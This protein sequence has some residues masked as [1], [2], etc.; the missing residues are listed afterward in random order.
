MSTYSSSFT[1]PEIG[2]TF[3]N[4]CGSCAQMHD[5]VGDN[6][7]EKTIIIK[8]GFYHIF[9]FYWAAQESLSTGLSCVISSFGFNNRILDLSSDTILDVVCWESCSNC[10]TSNNH[11]VSFNV[12]M[13]CSGI[14]PTFVAATILTMVGHAV[15][16]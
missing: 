5:N 7:W 1:N 11:V 2:G 10:F 3:N 4:W 12:D 13:N 16:G 9:M 15:V 6:I 14:N 8:E